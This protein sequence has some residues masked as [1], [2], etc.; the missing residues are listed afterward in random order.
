M[1]FNLLSVSCPLCC[2]TIQR[3]SL[4]EHIS[5]I[6]FNQIKLKCDYCN[7][8]ARRRLNLLSH[9]KRVHSC[10][11][12]LESG[13]KIPKKH[14]CIYCGLMTEN[15]KRHMLRAHKNIKNVFCDLCLYSTYFK[16]DLE[17]H[18]QVHINQ[19]LSKVQKFI[20]DVCGLHFK[21]RSQI[22]S[23]MKSQHMPKERN[24][25]CPICYKCKFNWKQ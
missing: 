12:D 4:I 16:P 7:Y 8:K 1:S 13:R 21:K 24:Y 14:H 17:N 10:A 5:V 23:H 20:C 9:L 3:Y 19:A 15:R 22:N 2:K 25:Q 18:M 11:I 6:H